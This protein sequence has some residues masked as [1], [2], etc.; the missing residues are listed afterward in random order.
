MKINTLI[1]LVGLK[2]CNIFPTND[3]KI[4]LGQKAF[5][6]FFAKLFLSKCGKKVNI[7][8]GATF[9]HRVELGNRS[10]IGA[11][12]KLY[13]QVIIGDDVMMGERCVIY[14]QNHKFDRID[15][16]MDEQGF[17]E[18]KP[19]VIG[20][21]VWIGGNVTILPGVKIGN[22]AILGACAVVTKSV[23]DYAI[24]GG[25]PARI[26]KYRNENK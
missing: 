22:G 23:P 17:Q 16:P 5:R 14:T 7:Q 20:N 15:I 19:V 2:I 18:E 11:K 26:I 13:G 6:R 10:G 1:G 12:S 9:S 4:N 21:D 8:K 25:N 24:V 3:S